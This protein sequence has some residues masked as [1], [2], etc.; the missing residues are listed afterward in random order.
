MAKEKHFS[1]KSE[2]F[3]KQINEFLSSKKGIHSA[4]FDLTYSFGK[5]KGFQFKLTLNKEDKT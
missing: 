2:L 4:E 3:F 5:H 1:Y